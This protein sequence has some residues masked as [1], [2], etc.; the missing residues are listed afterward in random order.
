LIF[1]PK[2]KKIVGK[3][4]GF[5]VEVT[6]R[7][8]KLERE[9]REHARAVKAYGV[10]VARRYIQRINII[11]QAHNIEELMALPV[12]R[13]HALKASRTGQYAAKLTGFY[14]LI[15]TLKGDASEI[16]QIEEVS[17]HYGD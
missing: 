6:F 13:C 2:G 11:K 7:T 8:R 4:W 9:Y 10:D 12:L 16:A 3:I 5:G 1:Y 14:R 15:F 17:K